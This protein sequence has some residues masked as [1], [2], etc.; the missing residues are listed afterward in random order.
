[1]KKFFLGYANET[2][3]VTADGRNLTSYP[4]KWKAS[5]ESEEWCEVSADSLEEA[6]LKYEATF[7]VWQETQ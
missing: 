3:E 1:M 7:K 2:V 6:K 5:Y 4:S